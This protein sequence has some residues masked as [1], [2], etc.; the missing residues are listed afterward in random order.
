MSSK[1]KV[2][3]KD[4]YIGGGE[5]VLIQSMTNTKTSD[6]DKTV[7]QILSLEECGCE[8]VRA[9]VNDVDAAK[10]IGKIKE[11]IHI[12]LVADI[13]FDYRLALLAVENGVDKVRINPGNIGDVSNVKKVADACR[14]KGIPIRIGVNGGSLDKEILKK[15]GSVT[16]EALVE[17]AKKEIKVLESCDFN[18]IV[19][20][21]KVSDTNKMIDAYTLASQ[22]FP[23]P[24]HIGVTEAGGGVAGIVKNAVG[25]GYLLRNGIGDTLRV[26]LTENVEKEIEAA[27]EILS[28][29]GV[30]KEWVEII[31]CPTCGRTEV[32]IIKLANEVK[33]KTSHIKKHIKIGVMGC[34]VNGPGEARECDI[35]IAGGKGCAVLFKKNESGET[36]NLGK[37]E[38]D[39]II[40]TLL[41]E[42]NK[43]CVQ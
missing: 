9:T 8:I 41:F 24:L 10:A 23:Y 33:R 18:D 3:I 38:E 14:Q 37:I 1:I 42:I 7:S 26:S 31:S 22:M 11:K 17:S 40:D 6:V 16:A 27:K 39:K 30:R 13:H 19:L 21:L 36:V 4:R 2:K 29:T 35:G 28:A 5:K 12:P 20:S 15:Y 32:D 43:M 25:I 34:V